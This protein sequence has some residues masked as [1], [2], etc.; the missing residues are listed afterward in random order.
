MDC[1]NYLAL[2]AEDRGDTTE[3]VAQY[4]ARLSARKNG[5]D[6]YAE[7]ARKRLAELLENGS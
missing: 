3:A 1:H 4:R 6:V 5:K 2:L 7:A